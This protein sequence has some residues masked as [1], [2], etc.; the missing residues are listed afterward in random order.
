MQLAKQADHLFRCFEWQEKVIAVAATGLFW[1]WWV[2]QN[3]GPASRGGSES[4]PSDSSDADAIVNLFAL[5]TK[6]SELEPSKLH[7]MTREMVD[8]LQWPTPDACDEGSCIDLGE[9]LEELISTNQSSGDK[10]GDEEGMD[11][12]EDQG[13]GNEGEGV[14]VYGGEGLIIDEGG[15]TREAPT[16]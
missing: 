3:P 7:R 13:T 14:V 2:I 4:I 12:I 15:G 1:A 6:A 11:L 8:E 9:Y 5:G 10:S 16:A